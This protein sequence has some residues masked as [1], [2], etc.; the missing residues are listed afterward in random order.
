MN[1]GINSQRS[2]QDNDVRD[3]PK[4]TRRYV[5][6]V[7]PILILFG[8]L[9]WAVL[10]ISGGAES[11]GLVTFVVWGGLWGLGWG[12]AWA[13]GRWLYLTHQRRTGRKH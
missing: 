5:W 10:A 11:P 7:V 13:L 8:I 9:F 12:L 2:T 1:Q 4:W 3:I 6:K